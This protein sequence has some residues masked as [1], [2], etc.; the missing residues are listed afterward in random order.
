MT[1][2]DGEIQIL[3]LPHYVE[4]PWLHKRGN[5]YYLTYASMGKGREMIH[6]ATAESIGGTWT[7]RGAL[8]GMAENSFTIHPGIIEFKGQWYL[9]Y[10]NA[11]LVIGNQAG[12]TGR[13][14]VCADYLY[15][16]PDGSMAYVEQTKAGLTQPP[17]TAEDVSRI[18]NPYPEEPKEVKKRAVN[19]D[20]AV[21]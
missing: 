16:L 9:F 12:A 1:E 15:Y 19:T 2:L 11:S 7:Y 20:G 10:H 21:K 5:L 3:E 14:S 4:G 6:Y 17:K 18:A 13:R 8:T